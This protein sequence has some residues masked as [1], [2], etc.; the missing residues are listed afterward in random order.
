M[1]NPIRSVRATID[2]TNLL[3]HNVYQVQLSL[4]EPVQRDAG[5]YC[6]LHLEGEVYAYSIASAPQDQQRIEL[7]IRVDDANSNA[8]TVINT[9]LNQE[10]VDVSLPY[11]DATLC[12]PPK[13]PVLMIAGSTGYSG[14]QSKLLFLQEQTLEHPVYFYWGGRTSD[15]LYLLEQAEQICAKNNQFV[16]EALVSDEDSVARRKGWLHEAVIEDLGDLSQFD[17]YLAGSPPMVYAIYDALLP[18]GLVPEQA[19]SDVFSYA[20]RD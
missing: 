18:Q 16:L 20:P 5:Q 3:N 1:T 2:S 19:Y 9:L 7:H 4:P 8:I 14:C 15:D 10:Q 11:G 12:E 6:M 13:R 17:V